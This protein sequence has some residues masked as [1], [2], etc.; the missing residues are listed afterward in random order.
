MAE[1]N[2][3]SRAVLEKH[4]PTVLCHWDVKLITKGKVPNVDLICGGFPCQDISSVGRKAG[5][6]GKKSGLWFEMHRIVREL[7]PRWVLIENVSDLRT[8]GADTVISNLEEIGYA[9]WPLLV[10]ADNVGATQVRKRCL[11]VAYDASNARAGERSKK[12]SAAPRRTESSESRF[13][14]RPCQPQHEYEPSRI[15]SS[16]GRNADG[17][18]TKLHAAHRRDRLCALGN[19]VVPQV[20]EAIGRAIMRT[21]A[22]MR[23]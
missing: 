15:E 7:R 19:A 23:H 9:S 17:L 2:P 10:G 22:A 14:S 8:R 13:P 11:L 1:A 18:S 12:T 6:T 4:W 3:Y 20:A 16:V 5:I 21:D